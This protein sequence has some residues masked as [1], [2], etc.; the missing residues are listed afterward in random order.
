MG[1]KFLEPIQIGSQTV[2]TGSSI[3]VMAKCYSGM[4]GLLV[5]GMLLT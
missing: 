1:H 5:P 3:W 4:D 2:K